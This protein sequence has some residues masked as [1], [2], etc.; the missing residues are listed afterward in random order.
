MT[1]NVTLTAAITNAATSFTYTSTG[2]PIGP[3]DSNPAHTRAEIEIDSE[4]MLVTSIN[5]GTNTYS[6]ITRGWNGTTPAAHAAGAQ[7]RKV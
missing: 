7:I 2:D 6:S 4:Q 3:S 5:E 1:P